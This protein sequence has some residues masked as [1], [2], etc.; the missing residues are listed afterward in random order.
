[1]DIEKRPQVAS[2]AADGTEL[3]Y[4]KNQ[5]LLKIIERILLQNPQ[6]NIT[7]D[8]YVL[9]ENEQEMTSLTDQ[10]NFRLQF[11]DFLLSILE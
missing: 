8:D 2:I 3:L 11:I 9:K 10:L 6:F 1:M 4:V 5:Y 7:F